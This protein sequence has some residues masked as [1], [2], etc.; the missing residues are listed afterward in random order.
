MSG[1]NLKVSKII[2]KILFQESIINEQEH[3]III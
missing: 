1:N 2:F 3:K